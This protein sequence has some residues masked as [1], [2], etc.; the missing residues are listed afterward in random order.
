[1]ERKVIIEAGGR[2]PWCSDGKK[3]TASEV[4]IHHID[5]NRANTVLE[6]L[7]LVCRNHHGQI[8]EKL[9]PEW[10]VQLKKT[11]LSNPA[12]LERLGL[13]PIFVAAPP[14]RQKKSKKAIV[15]GNNSGVAT[16]TIVNNSGII[17]GTVKLDKRPNGPIQV[18]GS[19][20][21]SV[22]HYGYVDY[23]IKRLSHYRSWRPGGG[24]PPDNPGAVRKIFEQKLGRLPKDFPL[25]RFDDAV[26]YLLSKIQSTALG[27]MGKAK[28][29]T[30][31]EWKRKG[32]KSSSVGTE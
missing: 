17:A 30:F 9:I 16:E 21:T 31:D 2:C 14:K 24:G 4:E 7:L 15:N 12:T 20:V 29:S 27:R 8:G 23:L 6:N 32:L 1:M 3:L 13:Q 19:L 18:V 11:C 10:E 5:G 28:V 26:A 25:D 22:E